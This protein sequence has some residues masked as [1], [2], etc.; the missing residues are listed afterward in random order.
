M[1]PALRVAEPLLGLPR[2]CAPRNDEKHSD[3][4]CQHLDRNR[5]NEHSPLAVI[6]LRPD[7]LTQ[8]RDHAGRS[9]KKAPAWQGPNRGEKKK[10]IG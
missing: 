7:L 6:R 3:R 2:R 1:V 10:P 4:Q 5:S 8:V 9:T